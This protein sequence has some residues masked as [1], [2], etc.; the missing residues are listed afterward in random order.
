M[1]HL[2]VIWAVH[3]SAVEPFGLYIPHPEY[4]GGC[5]RAFFLTV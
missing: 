5:G 4:M 3:L 1:S 2:G